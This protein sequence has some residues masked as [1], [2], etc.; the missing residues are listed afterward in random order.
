MRKGNELRDRVYGEA[1]EEIGRMWEVSGA[2]MGDTGRLK[3]L[4]HPHRSCSTPF[5]HPLF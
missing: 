5:L 2:L 3:S 4:H 1:V